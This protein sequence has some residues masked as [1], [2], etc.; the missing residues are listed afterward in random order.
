MLHKEE[1]RKKIHSA[2]CKKKRE[3]RVGLINI[4]NIHIGKALSA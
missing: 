4:Y 1:R 3:E 2:Q